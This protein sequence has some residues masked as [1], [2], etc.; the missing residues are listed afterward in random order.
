MITASIVTY[1]TKPNDL[2]RL[3]KCLLK[4]P[5]SCVYII[6]HSENENL[7]EIVSEYEKIEYI[8]NDNRGYGAGHNIG[9]T[10]GLESGAIYHL[11]LNPDVYWTENVIEQLYQYMDKNP[12][13]GAI[14]PK[15]LYPDGR[16][17]RL[18]KHLPTPLD[19]IVRRFIPVKSIKAYVNRKY[20][21]PSSNDDRIME[22]PVLS[23]CFMFFRCST[24]LKTGLFDERFFLYGEDVDLSR[25][26]GKIA[27]MI[28]FPH[29]HIFHEYAKSSY[30]DNKM[31]NIHIMS[32][33][34]YFNKWG[35]YF[36][37]DRR[38]NRKKFANNTKKY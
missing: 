7:K 13:C 12:E 25:R 21:F 8:H 10:K 38:V 22:I 29:V 16:E 17:Q 4:S 37:K 32:M 3:L 2:K 19:L 24:L 11:V 30:S 15:I 20:E 28:F 9:I 5:I 1:H 31:R 27:Y 23:G 35:W 34:K 14:M 33:I 18:C 36:D 6:D 26:V